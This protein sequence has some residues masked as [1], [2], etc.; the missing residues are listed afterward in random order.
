M[1][2]TA[3][4]PGPRSSS[5]IFEP[6]ERGF[7]KT[8]D[9]SLRQTEALTNRV[10]QFRE[11]ERRVREHLHPSVSKVTEGMATIAMKDLPENLKYP[12]AE[13]FDFI[14]EGFNLVG[15]FEHCP[16][17]DSKTEEE[18]FQGADPE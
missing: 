1:E 11:E 8:R 4:H 16:V 7:K 5:D 13:V 17:F 14:R 18:D 6:L 10:K 3:K 12:Y 2:R 15:N 9:R